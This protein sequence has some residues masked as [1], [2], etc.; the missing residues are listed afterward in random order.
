MYDIIGYLLI[1]S[2]ITILSYVFLAGLD[3]KKRGLLAPLA[4]MNSKLPLT[5][6]RSS[7]R[8]KSLLAGQETGPGFDEFLAVKEV[9]LFTTAVVMKWMMALP[10]WIC[11]SGAL[12]AFM[13]PDIK[14]KDRIKKR[15]REIKR[16]FIS[17]LDL[18]VLVFEAGLDFTG[19]LKFLY[20]KYP[21]G[22]LTQEV[23]N[24]LFEMKLGVPREKALRRFSD[25]LQDEDIR[26]FVRAVI[27]TEKSGGSL[28][29]VIRGLLVTIKTGQI[30]TAEKRANEAPVKLLG[31]LAL[32]I[33]PVVFIVLFGPILINLLK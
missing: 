30:Q 19:A 23:E 21:S 7:Y 9:A 2:G 11:F 4:R 8:A 14:L 29:K 1:F 28:A 5:F 31:P 20:N 33:F 32:F 17:F 24:V 25:R 18:M 15:R 13:L 12:V 10:L 26:N 3:L 6:Y 22:A 27:Q 16:S